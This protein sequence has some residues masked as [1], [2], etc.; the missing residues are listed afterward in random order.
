MSSLPGKAFEWPSPM[1]TGDPCG[2]PLP[3]AVRGPRKP[4]QAVRR[5]PADH[6]TRCPAP[7]VGRP[8]A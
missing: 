7:S 8:G 1:L 5:V 2:R 6:E 4:S 3:H